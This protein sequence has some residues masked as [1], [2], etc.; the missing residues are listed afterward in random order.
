A[1][2]VQSRG[3]HGIPAESMDT[4]CDKISSTDKT[5]L[6]VENSGHVVIREPEREVIF[7]EV[8]K[9]IKRITQ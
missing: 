4:L 7:T 3:D 5:R 2:M 8:K 6:W 1:L 9:F